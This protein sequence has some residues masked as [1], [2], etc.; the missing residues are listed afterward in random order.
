MLIA[1]KISG[2]NENMAANASEKNGV[3]TK[4]V[5]ESGWG[6]NDTMHQEV[7]ANNRPIKSMKL[8]NEWDVE[9][10]SPN[11][12]PRLGFFHHYYYNY[13]VVVLNEIWLG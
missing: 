1:G 3:K 9:N 10:T 12:I 4:Q 2:Q 6:K 8:F 7:S 5:N 13:R 11:C